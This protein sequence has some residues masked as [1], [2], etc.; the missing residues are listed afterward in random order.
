MNIKILHEHDLVGCGRFEKKY[1][2][3]F[4]SKWKTNENLFAKNHARRGHSKNTYTTHTHTHFFAEKMSF[5]I[6][7]ISQK[8]R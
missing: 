5:R 7:L 1:L 4:E 6:P 2:K 3:T 8:K